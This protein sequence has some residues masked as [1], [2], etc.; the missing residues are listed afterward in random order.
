MKEIIERHKRIALQFSGGKDSIAL[1]HLMRP[2]WDRLT[3]YWLDT[4]DSFPEAREIVEQVDRMVPRFE[5]IEGRQPSVIAQ[6]GIPS[7]IVPANATPIGIAAKGGGVLIQDRYSCCMRSLMMPMHEQMKADG[8]TLVIRGQKASD[9][10]R[11]PIKSGHVEDGIEYLFP[12]EAW[13][14]SR[15]FAFLREQGVALPRYYEVMRASPDCMSCSA[16]WEDG[17]AAYLKRH[18]PEAYEECQR[19]LN[20]ISDATAEAIAHFNMEIGR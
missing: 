6:F 8:I 16:Y 17:R 9:R 3:V 20:A 11:S 1:L 5:R 2:Y 13:D 15:V 14:D 12:L 18:H 10:M 4:G 7:D 19:R